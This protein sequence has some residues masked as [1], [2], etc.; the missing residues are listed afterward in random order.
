[1]SASAL[2]P[3][4]TA[5]LVLGEL[6]EELA[7]D[8]AGEGHAGT[9]G[10]GD[11]DRVARTVMEGGM[12][13]DEPP[14]PGPADVVRVMHV[15]FSLQ[16]GGMEH[17]IVKLV[18]G[19]DPARVRSAICSTIPGGALKPLVNPG[20]AVH[21]LNRRP[22]N[23][24]RLV[25]DLYRLFRRERPHIVHTHAWGT[26]VEGLIAARLAR[27]PVVIHGEHGTLQLTSRQ[28]YVQRWGW[29]AADQ[30]LSV[31]SRLAERLARDVGFPLPRVRTL[32]NGVDL[33]R[34]SRVDRVDARK[35]LNL[36]LDEPVLVTV[37]RLVPV[38]DHETL[39][40]SVQRLCRQGMSPTLL[41]AGDGPLMEALASRAA[42]LGIDAHV[43]W[44]GHRH[45]VESVFAAA[46]VFVLSSQ[47]EGLSNTILEAMAAGLPVVATRVGGADELVLDGLTGLL[48]PPGSPEALAE[49][50]ASVLRDP[51]A[52]RAMG[53]A[54][55]E[56]AHAEFSLD[57]MIGRYEALYLA[58]AQG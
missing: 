19:L 31:S 45:D 54:G 29:R 50:L 46:D 11:D 10:P 25:I 21:E 52:R 38:K 47:S 6:L 30:V 12:V 41:V 9:A 3:H 26:M 36:T 56:R 20:V 53:A 32:R 24:P 18:N 13:K 5:P 2:A 51:E 28:R 42:A 8:R 58:F 17:G 43:R 40:E 33:T 37:G 57:A 44:L 14:A 48:V 55:R 23:D 22:G 15:V 49:A 35:A 1:M 27:V 16:S 4:R 34:F 7:D 39:L